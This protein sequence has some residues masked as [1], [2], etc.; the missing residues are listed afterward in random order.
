MPFLALTRAVSPS[1]ADCEITHI[2]RTPI[3]VARASLQHLEYERT[4]AALGCDI[5][6][7]APAPQ[8]PDAV[9][10]E[11]TAVVLDEVA[12]ITRPGADSRRGETAGVV[13]ALQ[14]LR[15]LVFID[16]PGTVD[17][18]DVLVV[19]HRI[20]VGR[21]DRT[22][23]EGIRQFA[24]LTAPFG[25]EVIPVNVRGCLHLKTAVTALDDHTA[26]INPQWVDAE[27]LAPLDVVPVHADEPMGAN[28]VRLDDVLLYADSYPR[29]LELLRARGYRVV[30]VAADELAKAEG[31]VTCC[32][33]IVRV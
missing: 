27:A 7:V 17:G 23:D 19:A 15:P 10:I 24:T 33:L 13:A 5:R 31:A 12:V 4:L 18:G 22:N 11:D 32:S 29:T 6:H 20:Y 8:H 26:L 28:V 14:P 25:Y 21:T 2:D 1:I 9:F 30:T 16:A 3:N